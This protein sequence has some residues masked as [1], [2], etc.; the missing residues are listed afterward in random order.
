MN[1]ADFPEGGIDVKVL[2]STLSATNAP[3]SSYNFSVVHM[4][5]TD[6]SGKTVGDTETLTP[7]K[8]DDGITFHVSSLSPFAIGWYKSTAPSGGGGGGGGG[9]G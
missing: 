6:M 1:P 4:F 5:T 7:T 2:Y 3:N 8:L 9:G